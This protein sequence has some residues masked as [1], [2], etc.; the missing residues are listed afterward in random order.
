MSDAAEQTAEQTTEEQTSYMRV[1]LSN[2]LSGQNPT[3]LYIG[4][5]VNMDMLEDEE[6]FSADPENAAYRLDCFVGSVNVATLYAARG[7]VDQIVEQ[8]EIKPVFRA[9]TYD[10]EAVSDSIS[11]P[12]FSKM[13]HNDFTLDSEVEQW[14][15]TDLHDN[16]DYFDG[17]YTQPEVQLTEDNLDEALVGFTGVLTAVSR[18]K[19]S[20]ES[21]EER[22]IFINSKIEEPVLI[23]KPGTKSAKTCVALVLPSVAYRWN[24]I[25]RWWMYDEVATEV[26]LEYHYTDS[27]EEFRNIE[28]LPSSGLVPAEGSDVTAAE[29]MILDLAIGED[30]D[31]SA[32][33][34]EIDAEI[35]AE[36]AKGS[37]LTA[38]EPYAE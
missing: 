19:N 29:E 37:P 28:V 2:S 21:V 20:V 9:A 27:D 4:E 5:H 14:S 25:V 23:R 8:Y 12:D 30:E 13:L 7:D 31:T 15:N 6:L 10:G 38:T 18:V 16:I 24:E 22:P 26:T 1:R 34:A 17:D 35:D 36:L 33:D 11:F 3:S 32:E